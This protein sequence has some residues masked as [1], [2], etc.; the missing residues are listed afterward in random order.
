MGDPQES[1][2]V[3]GE[4]K[5]VSCEPCRVLLEKKAE[6]AWG[7]LRALRKPEP[8]GRVSRYSLESKGAAHTHGA[9]RA[10]VQHRGR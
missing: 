2:H 10:C 7:P 4:G 6:G 3:R 8:A 9:G 5:Q 1:K